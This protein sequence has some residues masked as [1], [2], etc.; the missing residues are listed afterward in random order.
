MRIAVDAFNLDADRRGMGR[1]VRQV[2]ESFERLGEAQITLVRR[3]K[4]AGS[5]ITPRDLRRGRFDAV[6]YPWNGMRFAPHA[7]SIVT[8]HDPF[9]FTFAHPNFVARWR[10]QRPIRQAIRKA[11]RIFAVSTWD[12]QELQRLFGVP[13]ERIRVVSP[14]LESFWRR[15]DIPSQSA[16][17]LFVAGPDKRKNAKM[18]F[19]AFDA[20]FAAEGPELVVAGSL[21]DEDERAFESMRAARRRVRPSDE[22]LRGLYSGALAVAVPSL[23]E[24]FGIPVLEAMACGAPVIA[25]NATALPE[26]AGG[27]A[28]LVP[29]SDSGAWR[30]ALVRVA[31]DET[32]RAGLRERG[33]RRIGAMDPDGYAKALIASA[34]QLRAAAR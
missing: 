20:A 1:L 3:G 18:L 16:Y 24:G 12:A 29:A 32:L 23:A 30:D 15:V 25:S 5:D 7:P 13:A 27:A 22:Q 14:S 21:S 8:I 2:L 6:W 9:A 31:T 26:T 34:A 17:V 19:E 4:G 11:D 28:L 10:E 33:M